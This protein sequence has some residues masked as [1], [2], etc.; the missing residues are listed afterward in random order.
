MRYLL[1]LL[2]LAFIFSACESQQEFGIVSDGAERFIQASRSGGQAIAPDE[3][4]AQARAKP[5]AKRADRSNNPHTR[6]LRTTVRTQIEVK[7]SGKKRKAISVEDTVGGKDFGRGGDAVEVDTSSP[8]QTE[9]TATTISIEEDFSNAEAVEVD[10]RVGTIQDIPVATSPSRLGRR[11]SAQ[12]GS[13]KLDILFYMEDRSDICVQ[14][15]SDYS[16]ENAFLAYL[17]PFDWQMSFAFY[18]DGP[19]QLIPLE[20]HNGEAYHTGGFFQSTK[21]D[22]LLSKGEYEAEM[23]DRFFSETLKASSRITFNDHPDLS[24]NHRKTLSDLTPD[25]AQR[26]SRNPLAGLDVLLSGRPLQMPGELETFRR[27][28]A[29][30][31]VLLLGNHAYY[32][33]KEWD[34]FFKK[35]SN[36]SIIALNN[37]LSNVSQSF[38]VLEGQYDFEF[39]PSC[40]SRANSSKILDAI[41]S[42]F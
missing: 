27:P 23:R 3:D 10:I 4:S 17:D 29:K 33:S 35:H 25:K 22:Y 36:V 26:T 32:S 34:K 37:R 15:L 42:K 31:V 9:N 12:S 5:R 24:N 1:F 19:A 11:G 18:S 39:V 14:S 38:S 28:G 20:Y 30:T 21:P 40:D 2:T 8:V 16:S 41:K 7:V 13:K 6:Q